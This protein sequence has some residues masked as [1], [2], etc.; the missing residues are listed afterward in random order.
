MLLIAKRLAPR[1]MGFAFQLNAF[2][3]AAFG[4]LEHDQPR[5]AAHLRNDNDLLHAAAAPSARLKLALRHS[6]HPKV[7]SLSFRTLMRAGP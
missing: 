6:L 1:S 3:C 2:N 4:T 5:I 7:F